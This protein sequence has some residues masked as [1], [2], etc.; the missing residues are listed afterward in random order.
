MCEGDESEARAVG[1][2][3]RDAALQRVVPKVE[4]TKASEAA[5]L[6]RYISAKAV[7]WQINELE[8]G[9]VAEVRGDAA[10]EVEV[11]KVHSHHTLVPATANDAMPAAEV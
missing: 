7:V 4:T 2:G 10:A 3:G 11:A 8:E 1:E 9:Q 6:L 5:Y